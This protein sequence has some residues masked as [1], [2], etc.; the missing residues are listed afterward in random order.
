MLR[1][2]HSRETIARW[3]DWAPLDEAAYV[4]AKDRLISQTLESLERY[5]PGVG[6]SLP[7]EVIDAS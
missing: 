2:L 6:A 1:E 3:Q 4:S 7:E 5:V